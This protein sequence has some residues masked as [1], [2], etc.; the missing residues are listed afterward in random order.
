MLASRRPLNADWKQMPRSRAGEASDGAD[1]SI[2]TFST[3]YPNATRPEHGIF[4]ETRLRH[5]RASGR[6]LGEVIA[7]SPW[8]P[9][10]AAGFGRYAS[11]ARV[12][13]QETRHGIVVHHPRYPLVPKIG[14]TSAPFSL[15]AAT[16]PLLRQLL[17]LGRRFDLID[18][19][20]FYPD[21]VAAILLGRHFGIP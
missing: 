12:P 13:K 18:A 17:R 1:L 21:G 4:V 8:F 2:L 5:L 16:V 3:L 19:H 11:F 20:Y 15:Y 14:M 7:P 6:V 9:F 10:A